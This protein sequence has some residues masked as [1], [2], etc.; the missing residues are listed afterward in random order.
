MIP[1]KKYGFANFKWYEIVLCTFCLVNNYRHDFACIWPAINEVFRGWGGHIRVSCL[2]IAVELRCQ[3]LLRITCNIHPSKC[4]TDA[5]KIN[6]QTQSL[7]HV[8]QQC[9]INVF[10]SLCDLLLYF[11]HL[12]LTCRLHL[13]H[14][15]PPAEACQR[16]SLWWTTNARS[17][18]PAH[19]FAHNHKLPCRVYSGH[20]VSLQLHVPWRYVSLFVSI[21][22]TSISLTAPSNCKKNFC[23]LPT[24]RRLPLLLRFEWCS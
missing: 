23:H 9:G 14:F 5:K 8:S 3:P 1:Y 19:Q 16:L 11:S 15:D 4:D 7:N 17:V 24:V 12:L 18:L 13:V 22:L 10:I 20:N 2:S 6:K 21:A